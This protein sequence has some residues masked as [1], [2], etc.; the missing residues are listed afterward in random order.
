MK[1]KHW[2]HGRS[3]R[4]VGFVAFSMLSF[5]L[6]PRACQAAAEP[7]F[8]IDARSIDAPLAID[9]T[10][11][12]AR[13]KT[14]QHVSLAWDFTNRRAASESTEAYVLIDAEFLYVAFVANQRE[15]KTETQHVNDVPLSTDDTVTVDVWPGGKN[16]I[17]YSFTI[18]PIGTHYAT[19]SE[20]TTFAPKWKATGQSNQ[21][22]YIVTARIPFD[23]MRGDGRSDWLLQFSRINQ[24]A[25]VTSEWAHKSSQGTT[26]DPSYAGAL[27]GMARSAKSTR[28]RPRLQVYALA[29]AADSA[30]GGSTS[31][32]GA[33]Y[34]IPITRTASFF[35]T[36]H[37]DYSNVELDQ[38]TISPTVFPRQ[39]QEIRPFFTQGS[40]FYNALACHD[41]VDFPLL[42][43]P[44]IP[45]PT[46]GYAVEGTQ[47]AF[48]FAAFDASSSHRV[49]TAETLAWNSP[50]RRYAIVAQ[51]ES[52]DIV[53][54]H[55]VATYLQMSAG[56]VH[57]FQA[58]VTS[59]REDG[60]N[61]ASSNGGTYSELGMSLFTPKSAIRVA[62]HDVG[63]RYAPLDSFTTLNDVNGPIVSGYREFDFGARSIVESITISQDIERFHTR[64]GMLNYT[65]DQSSLSTNFRSQLSLSLSTGSNYV[66]QPLEPG[67]F[68]N[69]NGVSLAYKG[70]TSTPTSLS[71]NVGRFGAGYLKSWS[72]LTT[73]ELLRRGTLSLEVDDNQNILDDRKSSTQWLERASFAYQLDT[74]SSLA[75]GVRRIIGPPPA[76]F[77]TPSDISATNL[78]LAF[79]RSFANSELYFVYGDA[80]QV[81]TRHELILKFI[82]Y[83]GAQKGT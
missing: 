64:A 71:Y 36:I 43:T 47:Q 12:D 82:Q 33:D 19:S 62:Y 57:N 24:V 78:S 3:I 18:N 25:N 61:I 13:W 49:D 7:P 80:N 14:A 17:E 56:N 1:S 42:Y 22:G 20:N 2:L 48:S 67:G 63:P 65:V 52:A 38:Q 75:I 69:Q 81:S 31:R 28:T 26:D 58:Y 53:N 77:N 50:D 35:G 51:R 4:M 9:G 79:Y 76:F 73:F 40:N 72:R 23:V 45:T 34:A 11:G 37:P 70:N 66:L 27:T 55:D 39:F 46:D 10:L 60:T 21:Q 68:A 44:A 5:I 74:T 59:G 15:S 16:G 29:A 6:A 41:C 32:V 8:L 54:D 83:I 30:A